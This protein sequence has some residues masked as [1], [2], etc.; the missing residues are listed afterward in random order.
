MNVEFPIGTV[1][2]GDACVGCGA[3]ATQ[4]VDI[5]AKQ[6][7]DL[8]FVSFSHVVTLP[9][10][11]CDECR[12]RH[13]VWFWAATAGLIG[14]I[15]TMIAVYALFIHPTYGESG[16]SWLVLPVL[17]ILYW[18]RNQ[19]EP[20]V[21]KRVLHVYAKSLSK[22]RNTVTLW[23]RDP[24]LAQAMKARAAELTPQ[25]PDWDIDVNAV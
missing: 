6:G 9:A 15:V 8:I 7:I 22:K 10:P 14:F 19:L 20:F 11:V 2:F 16:S 4:D 17:A 13:R 24:N 23:F 12:I 18:G 1:D 21:D 25:T 3:I 5:D